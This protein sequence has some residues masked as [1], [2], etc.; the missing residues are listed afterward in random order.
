MP[1]AAI[2]STVERTISTT[3]G[4]VEKKLKKVQEF[5][6]YDFVFGKKILK[7]HTQ[8]NKRLHRHS[9]IGYILALASSIHN[10]QQ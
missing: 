5:L 9:S 8:F 10:K 1:T 3:G 7:F 2:A 6:F 4:H